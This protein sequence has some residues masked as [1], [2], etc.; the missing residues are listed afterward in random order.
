MEEM[1]GCGWPEAERG[2]LVPAVY[3]SPLSLFYLISSCPLLILMAIDQAFQFWPVHD[4][5]TVSLLFSD[6]TL[7]YSKSV[8][9]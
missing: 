3:N 1:T 4:L 9:F 8:N 6:L 5:A 2:I 7:I